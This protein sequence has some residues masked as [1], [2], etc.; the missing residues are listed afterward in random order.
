[1]NKYDTETEILTEQHSFHKLL[2]EIDF[3]KRRE[4]FNRKVGGKKIDFEFQELGLEL[5]QWFGKK[6]YWL[7]YKPEAD[8]EKV[9]QAF[10][11]C[12]DKG[13]RKLE[14]LIGII[15]KK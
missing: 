5:E 4:E 11:V 6:L 8:L 7:F 10:K 15:K 2:L 14:Y 12:R 1:M 9:K 13:I 3:E